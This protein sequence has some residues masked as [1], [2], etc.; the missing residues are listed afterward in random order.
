MRTLKEYIIDDKLK[1]HLFNELELA[2]ECMM[3]FYTADS[4]RE[5]QGR[6]KN[7][8]L[9]V[10]K[11]AERVTKEIDDSSLEECDGKNYDVDCKDCNAYCK[12]VNV[13]IETN[14]NTKDCGASFYKVENDTIFMKLILNPYWELEIIPIEGAILHELLHAYENNEKLLAGKPSIFDELSKEY[15]N[16]REHI[17]TE[18]DPITA[19][20]TLKYYLDP[21]E[22]NAFFGALEKDIERV[23]K[24]V[25]PKK[26]NIKI[27]DVK[28][29]LQKLTSWRRYFEFNRF[30]HELDSYSDRLL[31]K[32][33]YK[34]TTSEETQRAHIDDNMKRRR[35][36]EPSVRYDYVKSASEIRKE[37][38]KKHKKFNRKFN[39][40]FPKILYHV[41]SKKTS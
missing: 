26:Y 18:I 27:S 34:A 23:I 24:D 37:V 35:A 19:M 39:Q 10:R 14:E 6:F 9:V 32:S 3:Y 5:D 16:A 36:G 11:I 20:T 33:Y 21:H 29:R 15:D 1:R 12:T 28:E 22:R 13:T 40:L 17:A 41:L 7:Y 31:E 8:D 30:V 2:I 4:I 25:D 38:K